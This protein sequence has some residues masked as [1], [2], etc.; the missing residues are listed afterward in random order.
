MGCPAS[1]I[2]GDTLVFS[3]CTHDPDT[4]ALA[5]ADTDPTWRIYEE[6]TA[7]AILNGIMDKLDDAST[8]GFYTEAVECTAL[9]GFE[10]GKTYTVYIEATV[11]SDTGGIAYAFNVSHMAFGVDNA[12]DANMVAI[13]EVVLGGSGVQGDP[14]GPE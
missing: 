11:N 1:V 4:G 6:E 12:V 3:I 8:T 10:S 14:W 13:N 9:N 2:L 5:D 7:S